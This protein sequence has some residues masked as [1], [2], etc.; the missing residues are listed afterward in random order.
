MYKKYPQA[1]QYRSSDARGH[2]QT[3]RI[4]NSGLR[5]HFEDDSSSV[6]DTGSVCSERPVS[7]WDREI[8][9]MLGSRIEVDRDCLTSPTP[10]M[11]SDSSTRNRLTA[12]SDTLKRLLQHRKY[13]SAKL[14]SDIEYKLKR[15][16]ISSDISEKNQDPLSALAKELEYREQM[17]QSMNRKYKQDHYK[18]EGHYMNKSSHWRVHSPDSTPDSAIDVDTSS[19]KSSGSVDR[20]INTQSKT[21]DMQSYG[22]NRGYVEAENIHRKQGKILVRK[23]VV[24]KGEIIKKS[25][26]KGINYPAYLSMFLKE[27]SNRSNLEIFI[28]AITFKF[29]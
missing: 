23:G 3:R 17:L 18:N 21:Q 11:M 16:S 13:H 19:V 15:S 9:N 7:K 27:R 24:H 28:F 25:L 29:N 4:F 10:S 2:R 22:Q 12:T 20:Q 8:E 5:V 1:F 6:I 14:V 26:L